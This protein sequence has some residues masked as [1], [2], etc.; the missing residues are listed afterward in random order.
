M[1]NLIASELQ[2][3][4]LDILARFVAILSPLS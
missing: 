2:Y 4:A 1:V 3:V